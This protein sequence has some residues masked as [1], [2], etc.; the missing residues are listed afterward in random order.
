MVAT[1]WDSLQYEYQM[2]FL[3]NNKYKIKLVDDVMKSIRKRYMIN[4]YINPNEDYSKWFY[5][6]YHNSW[7]NYDSDN[8]HNDHDEY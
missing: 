4:Y 6:E 5:D 7:S 8:E 1:V 3:S 2:I